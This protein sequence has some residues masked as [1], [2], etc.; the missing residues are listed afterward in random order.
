MDKR[1]DKVLASIEGIERAQAPFDAFEKIQLKIQTQ[2]Q[3]VITL[4]LL[5]WISAAASIALIV[6]GNLFFII[7]YLG[8]SPTSSETG[9]YSELFSDFNI[10]ADEK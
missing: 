7:S 9:P 2:K 3:V 4:S 6:G 1:I 10:Y 8:Q 5:K